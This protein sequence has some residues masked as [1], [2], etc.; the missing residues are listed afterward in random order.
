MSV[1]DVMG[2]NRVPKLGRSI[3]SGNLLKDLKN[4]NLV[5]RRTFSQPDFEQN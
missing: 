1:A 5:L 2:S 4:G 3:F